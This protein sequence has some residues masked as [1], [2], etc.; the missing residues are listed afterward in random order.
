MIHRVHNDAT[1]ALKAGDKKTAEALRLLYS[2]L[3]NAE[4][5]NMGSLTEEQA[6]QVIKK[7]MKKRVEAR[8]LFAANDREE[9]AAKEEFERSLY[10]QYAPAELT[11]SQ[12]DDI[13]T[14]VTKDADE[15]SFGKLM[16]LVMKETKGSADGRMVSERVKAFI[17]KANNAA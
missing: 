13:I 1:A 6:I 9:M 4:I 10:S 12:I 14:S 3:K 16:P 11:A 2:S 5:E 15:L 7:E 8:D 17:D